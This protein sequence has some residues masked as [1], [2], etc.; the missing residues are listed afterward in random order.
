MSVRK[1][2][3]DQVVWVTRRKGDAGRK[4]K[5]IEILSS[6]GVNDRIRLLPMYINNIVK[7]EKNNC[8]RRTVGPIFLIFVPSL[9]CYVS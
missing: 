6:N 5:D 7:M 1:Q 4:T 9:L 2:I 3:D 8:G